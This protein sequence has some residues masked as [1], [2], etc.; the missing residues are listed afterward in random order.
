MHTSSSSLLWSSGDLP[1]GKDLFAEL[2]WAPTPSHVI[3]L[4]VSNKSKRSL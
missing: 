1:T 2:S 4:R 3:A